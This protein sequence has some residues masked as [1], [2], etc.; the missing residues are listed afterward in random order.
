MQ[1]VQTEQD[2]AAAGWPRLDEGDG[3]ETA[4][5]L[6]LWS[7]IVG[8]T[9]LAL[10][11]MTNHWWQVALYVSARGLTT[12]PI[13]NGDRVFEVE[14]DLVSHRLIMRSSDGGSESMPL[15]DGPL[16]RFYAE[17]REKLDRLRIDVTMNPFSVEMPERIRLDEDTRPRRYDSDWANRFFRALASVDR[18]LK[19]F[20]AGF[21][22]KVSPVHF[23]WGGFDLA[24]TRFSGRRAPPHPGGVPHVADGVM[25]EAYSH[26]VSSAGFWPGDARFPEPAFYSYAYPEPPGMP[27]APV[28]PA[29]AGYQRALGEFVLP[30]AAV[31][32]A[33]APAADA[34]AFLNSSYEAAADLARWDRGALERAGE[35]P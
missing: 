29:A 9:R 12:S 23:F 35:A 17:Y 20:R 15:G 30:Y 11:P 19:Q 5:T 16:A 32:S 21:A 22:G 28:R 34:L 31:R 2:A 3:P 1:A 14:M 8:K 26:E 10:C 33:P 7:Q 24:V 4:S 27:D 25:R 13:P 6:Q 18:I